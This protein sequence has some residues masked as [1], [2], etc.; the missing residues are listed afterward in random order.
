MC[1]NISFLTQFQSTPDLQIPFS[2][3]IQI[4]QNN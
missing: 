4:V 3:T 1:L 2:E